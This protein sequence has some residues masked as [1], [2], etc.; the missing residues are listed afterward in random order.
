MSRII[1]GL[2]TKSRQ[3][4]EKDSANPDATVDAFTNSVGPSTMS[5]PR[6]APTNARST[7]KE[8]I[9]AQKKASMAA[10]HLP[11]RPNSAMA[12][13]SPAKHSI[14][15]SHRPTPSAPAG[16][17]RGLPANGSH[18]SRQPLGTSSNT[19]HGSL[20]SGPVRRPR[21]PEVSRPA[22]ADP[23]TNRRTLRGETP[24][25]RSPGNSPVRPVSKG[26]GSS[27]TSSY[28]RSTTT[29]NLRAAAGDSV[30]SSRATSPRTSPMKGKPKT[31]PAEANSRIPTLSQADEQA[32]NAS[33]DKNFT[34]VVPSEKSLLRSPSSFQ[35]QRPD[36]DR[37]GTSQSSLPM[38]TE[39]DN[40]T[41][42]MPVRGGNINIP[43]LRGQSRPD[44]GEGGIHHAL[45]SSAVAT[46][47]PWP[48]DSD[49]FVYEDPNSAQAQSAPEEPERAVLEEVSLNEHSQPPWPQR[50][51]QQN[52][53]AYREAQ[54]AD[55]PS[56][57]GA[58]GKETPAQDR[59]EALKIG[60]LIAS[61]IDRLN[62]RALD[63][64]G[65]R[66][67]QDLV[68][69]TSKDS[70]T[71]LAGLLVA[72]SDY[73]E[74]PD[75]SLKVNATRAQNLK[76]QALA[77]MRALLSLHRRELDVRHELSQC[78]GA[79]LMAKKA[80]D[81]ISH[82]ALDLD[83]TADEVVHHAQDQVSN[84][85]SKVLSLMDSDDPSNAAGHRRLVTMALSVLSKLVA[86]AHNGEEGLAAPQLE[87]VA[88]LA[89]KSLD[90]TDSDVRRADIGLCMELFAVYGEERKEEFWASLKGAR[91]SQLNLVAYYL[92][93]RG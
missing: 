90:D 11:D 64:H 24:P 91:E 48:E 61:G 22:T 82:M 42:V 43:V 5:N 72:L 68:K 44:E 7:L 50:D 25:L 75:E 17:V 49:M 3:L 2:D 27:N 54:S 36:D 79:V 86:V 20:M 39:E 46:T 41:M 47:T 88:R 38:M 37:P 55:S 89:V 73:L 28:A 8:T 85:V 81:M 58:P 35:K 13:L 19:S 65:F 76:S 62:A 16:S 69:S 10:K 12:T 56:K 14:V 53:D 92:A 66:R 57:K 29:S 74:A 52:H 32:P 78:L 31:V 80:T 93:R 4:L 83:K 33:E 63:P 67:L 30:V 87:H 21:K 71:H 59:A 34:M 51:G 84:C 40:F 26:S 70:G 15:S 9:A 1:N 18:S 6:A 60:R 23:Y 45:Q 77:T